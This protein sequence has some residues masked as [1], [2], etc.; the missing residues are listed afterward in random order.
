MPAF[1]ENMIV[2]TQLKDD[3]PLK[4]LRVQMLRQVRA[5]QALLMRTKCVQSTTNP[6]RA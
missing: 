5:G 6:C 1:S 2:R 3:V 4:V